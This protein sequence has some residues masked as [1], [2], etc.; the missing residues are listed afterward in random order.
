M[1]TVMGSVAKRP[2]SLRS[3]CAVAA[4]TRCVHTVVG[5]AAKPR[6]VAAASLS[7]TT[8]AVAPA[9]AQV[10]RGGALAWYNAQLRVRPLTTKALTCSLLCGTAD[11]TCQLAFGD[12][13]AGDFGGLDWRRAARFAFCGAA[14]TAPLFHWWFSVLNRVFPASGGLRSVARKLASDMLIMAVPFNIMFISTLYT[15][16]A[17]G[18]DPSCSLVT[19]GLT[20]CGRCQAMIG[21]VMRDYWMVWAPLQLIN[22]AVVP[23]PY[24]VL[25]MNIGAFFWNVYLAWKV[26][27]P[28]S[29][30]AAQGANTLDRL[31]VGTVTIDQ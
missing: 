26:S 18:D 7:V 15:I 4:R 3:R 5:S 29:V 6:A 14:I 21:S 16:E 20:A 30:D 12:R 25:F 23:L 24:Q 31:A 22:F 2:Q 13:R 28:V 1:Y 27:G 11:V 17:L 9:P 10:Q 8:H 19:A